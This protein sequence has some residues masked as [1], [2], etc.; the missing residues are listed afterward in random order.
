MHC[1]K[2]LRFRSFSGPYFPAFGLNTEIYSVNLRIQFVCGKIRT[3]KTPNTDTFYTVIKGNDRF[4]KRELKESSL[5]FLTVIK[6]VHEP[7]ISPSKS[8]NT[9]PGGGQVPA[10]FSLEPN[11]EAIA[12][13]KDYSTIRNH[14]KEGRGIPITS[15]KYVHFALK[16]CNDAGV[17]NLLLIFNTVVK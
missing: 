3:R 1:V 6:S 10:S 12:F 4:E 7:N 9:V 14:F 11:W 15:T 5:H 16:C 17:V 13:T 2:G 8:I